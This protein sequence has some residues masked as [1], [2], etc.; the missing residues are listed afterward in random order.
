M[1]SASAAPSRHSDTDPC[2][3]LRRSSSSGG[4]RRRSRSIKKQADSVGQVDTLIQPQVSIVLPNTSTSSPKSSPVPYPLPAV[5]KEVVIGAANAAS[6]KIG[7]ERRSSSLTSNRPSKTKPARQKSRRHTIDTEGKPSTTTNKPSSSA[8]SLSLDHISKLDGPNFDLGDTFLSPQYQIIEP[9][10]SKALHLVKQLRIH[11]FAWVRR[12]S[13]EWT[14]AIIA[15]FPVESGEG[16]SIRFVI[17]KLGKTKTFE[18]KH[19]AKCIRL[20]DDKSQSKL[21]VDW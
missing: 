17:D 15:D 2:S 5:E 14:Y 7:G 18:M 21:D 19:W 1:R 13:H 12:S 6:R 16:T 20:V 4:D 8:A 9:N 3:S 11:D 10:P